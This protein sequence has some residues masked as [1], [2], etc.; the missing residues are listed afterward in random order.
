MSPRPT[1]RRADVQQL[2]DEGYE[3][4]FV[5]GYMLVSAI[6]YVTPDR[7]V[8]LGTLVCAYA[9]EGKPAD[10]TVWFKGKTPC[11]SNGQPLSHVINNSEE[12]VLFDD[13]KITH[14]FSN[15]Q[16]DVPDFP[17]DYYVKIV[18]YVTKLACHARVIDANADARTG[19]IIT[20]RDENSVFVYPDSALARNGIV[21][22]A[23]KLEMQRVAIVGLG[24]CGSYILDQL[25]KTRVREIHLFDGKNFNR[26]NAFRAPG[27]ASTQTLENK[28]T[29][30][31]YFCDLYSSMHR[32]IVPHP[33][34]LTAENVGELSG[35][36]FAFLAL[37]DGP[38]RAELSK[39][40][41]AEKITFIDVG[42]GM[43][44]VG[45]LNS[46]I[47][48]GRVTMFSDVKNDHLSRL[49]LADDRE[50][51]VYNNIQA[52]DMNAMAAI[53]AVQR[54]KQ[55]CGFYADYDKAHNLNFSVAQMSLTRTEVPSPEDA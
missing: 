19:K 3:V 47:S 5:Q 24:G 36:N 38:S 12:Q 13:F 44:K 42:I 8:D 20:D 28:P 10:H 18:H 46:L 35:F 37:D 15:K 45:E 29:K 40:L 48:L 11:D 16:T 30:V 7:D 43:E 17:A 31:Q 2:L 21:A 27:A 6:P 1:V 53:L 52:A 34:F 26:H 51:A 39:F 14:Y 9:D 22:I 49:P 4:S 41:L 54:W 33:H 32:G 25:A 55:H 23:Q 50:E